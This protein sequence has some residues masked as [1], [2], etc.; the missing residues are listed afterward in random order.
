MS[1]QV[2]WKRKALSAPSVEEET[3]ERETTLGIFGF[4][5]EQ[6]VLKNGNNSENGGEIN[7]HVIM[8]PSS[9]AFNCRCPHTPCYKTFMA[10]RDATARL[11]RAVKGAPGCISILLN[12]PLNQVYQ[13]TICF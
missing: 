5:L 10:E 11:R 1:G 13:R 8:T 7:R 6:I 3:A 4:L 2:K 12:K 9:T